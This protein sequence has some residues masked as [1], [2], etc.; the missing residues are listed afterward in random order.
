MGITLPQPPQLD[1]AGLKAWKT[2]I[3]DKLSGGVAGLL[4]AAKVRQI[5]GWA[6]FSD[7]KT[8]TVD[9]ANGEITIKAENVILAN[10]SREIEIPSLPFS[11]PDI[12]SSSDILD[13]EQRPEFLA[14]VGAGYIGME[15]GIV[16]AKLG[17]K[18]SFVE[19]GPVILP[20]YDSELTKPVSHWLEQNG[21]EVHLDCS[22]KELVERDGKQALAFT[23]SS[24]ET[25]HLS[26]EKV[27]VAVGRKP[28][29]ADWGLDTMGVD[30]DGPFIA[31]DNRCRTAMSGVYAI[32]DVTGEPLL[33]HKATAQGEIVAEIIAGHKRRFDPVSIAAVCFTSPE[34]AGVGLSPNQAKAAGETVI[35]GKFPLAASGKA[36][37]MDAGDDRGFVR[38]TARESDHVDSGDPRRRQSCRRT[39]RRVRS[40]AGNGRASGRH[41]PYDP[42]ASDAGRGPCRSCDD[43]ART[44][45]SYCCAA[46]EV[47]RQ[48]R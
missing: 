15:L 3:V 4:K 22:A 10:G 11:H 2:G 18:V 37:S 25:G 13:I 14:V 38:V 40:G 19:A 36:L 43:G 35:T 46:K 7:A 8:C 21:V 23:R 9:T 32:G 33:A 34:I 1:M 42:C 6:R 31:I 30:M 27:L 26:A 39:L 45:D 48:T 28:L 16:F 47:G 41:R 17:T 29:T 5:D 12:L 44:S 24:G 20:S